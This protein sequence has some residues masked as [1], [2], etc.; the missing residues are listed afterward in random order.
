MD[1][2][3]RCLDVHSGVA[4]QFQPEGAAALEGSLWEQA[5]QLRQQ[6]RQRQ[7]GSGGQST[8]PERLG[9]LVTAGHSIAVGNEIGEEKTSL[10]AGQISV[11][12]PTSHSSRETPAEL[13]PRALG[14]WLHIG[15]R[16]KLPPMAGMRMW[17]AWKR[18][19][20]G[21]VQWPT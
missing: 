1:S 16:S 17:P 8:R 18:S 12:P 9:E 3:P 15:H 4:F 11:D 19:S 20:E 10:P 7:V 14:L 2:I 13:N 5:P 6:R 21:G